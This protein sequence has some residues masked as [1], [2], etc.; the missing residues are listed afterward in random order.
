[1]KASS[2][3]QVAILFIFDLVGQIFDDGGIGLDPTQHEGFDEVFESHRLF[4]IVFALDWGFVGFAKPRLFAQK[5]R[6]QKIEDRP[7]IQKPI[8]HGRTAE[9][10]TMFGFEFEDGLGLF[11]F[12][13]FD[14]LCFVE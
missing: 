12:G 10:D 9:C 3:A 4:R 14:V 13:I 1:M 7:K 2:A 8:F 5:A 11:G 6:V